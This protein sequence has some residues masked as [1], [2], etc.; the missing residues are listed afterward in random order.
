MKLPKK[1]LTTFYVFFL[2]PFLFIPFL[3]LQLKA[4]KDSGVILITSLF[5]SILSFNYIAYITNDK[6]RYIERFTAFNKYSIQDLITYYQESFRPDYI[7]D[8]INYIVSKSQLSDSY[9]FLLITFTTVFSLLTFIRKSIRE[10]VPFNFCNKTFF[11]VLFSLSLPALF[12]G[13]RFIFAGSMF[14]WFIYSFYI[15]KEKALVI[16]FVFLL[17]SISTHFSYLYLTLPVFFALFALRTGLK[18][19]YLKVLLVFSFLSHFIPPIL[20]AS[21]FDAINL[22]SGFANKVEI[23]TAHSE[24]ES[25]YNAKILDLIKYSWYYFSIPV[26]LLYKPKNS[27]ALLLLILSFFIFINIISPIP[28]AY[29]RYLGFIK[30]IFAIF[31]IKEF[32]SNNLQKRLFIFLLFLYFIGFMTDILVLRTNFLESY[33]L[34]NSLT[35]FHVFLNKSETYFLY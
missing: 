12:S 14:V 33:S 2:S 1:S 9:F 27:N 5:L 20:F 24:F 23:Y 4:K 6:A 3:I 32:I 34:S 10:D 26:L 17:L 8:F 28:T 19:S 31:I 25:S 11:L 21:L 13:V 35:L 7:F 16:S 29:Y 30:I 15:K 18:V 22:P